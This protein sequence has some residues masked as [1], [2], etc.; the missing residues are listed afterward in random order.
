MN[1]I[2]SFRLKGKVALVT[3]GA[4]LFGRQIV[5]ALAEAGAK[6]YTASRDLVKLRLQAEQLRA[7]GLEVEALELD[8]GSEDSIR[9]IRARMDADH[10]GVDILVNNAVARPM[11]DWSSP[12]ADFETSLRV[13]AV[14]LFL[15]IREFGERMAERG[16]GSILNIG[17]IQGMVG[18]DR[19]LYEGLDWG[20]PPD[21][22]F[23]KGGL[24]Q[25]TRYA[26]AI[27]GPRGV[28]V[29]AISPGGFF[30]NQ[31]P[32]FVKRYEARTFLGR[33]AGETDLKGA[34]VFLASDASAYV[35]GANLVVDG[36]YTGK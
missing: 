15:M 17:S 11:R 16:G 22:F 6:A 35:T 27:L 7:Q 31:D 30:N 19:A 28:R 2:D 33:M 25:L 21:Y 18:P 20:I 13:N 23:H 1:V 29:N 24:L 32:T 8:Q 5:E 12:A 26:A 34:V 3:G 4:G 14:G 10:G 9:Q 36:G